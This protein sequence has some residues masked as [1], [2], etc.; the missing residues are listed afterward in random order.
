MGKI[1]PGKEMK[2]KSWIFHSSQQA[3]AGFA[4]AGEISFIHAQVIRF[5]KVQRCQVK[6]VNLEVTKC[7]LTSRPKGSIPK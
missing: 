1:N 6:R 3:S 4:I 7:F 5:A 2:P